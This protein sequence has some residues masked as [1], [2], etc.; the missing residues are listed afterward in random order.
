MKQKF[1]SLENILKEN[2][3]YNIIFGERSNGKTT[4]VLLYGLKRYVD[5]GYEK[6]MAIIRRW[7]EDFKG[8]K[9]SQLFAAIV[10]LGYVATYTNNL[11]NNVCYRAGK[12][13]LCNY[14]DDGKLVDISTEP[15]AYAFS[16][17][18]EE[19]YKSISFPNIKTV[20]FDE[21]ITR[22][23]Y[24]P[25]E[26]IKFQNLLSTIIRLNDDVKIFMCGNTVNQFCPYFVEMGLTR[27]ST[28]K[29]GTIDTYQYGEN[30]L[31]VAVEYSTFTAS[32]KRSNKY[33]AFDNPKLN[34]IK[35]GSWEIAI[36]PHLPVKYHP[37]EIVYKYY[38][39]FNDNLLQCEIIFSRILQTTFTF[40][41]RKTS[42]ISP[43]DPGLVFAQY[44]RPERR[45]R[46]NISRPTDKISSRIW[47]YFTD[48]KVFYQDNQIGE[49]VRNF[50]MQQKK[51]IT[52]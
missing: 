38:I 49:V 43:E 29:I 41:H 40:I 31:K 16:L 46:I 13:Y 26:F 33:F 11:F 17:T 9:A 10:N 37:S 7:D 23:Y 8:S 47:K 32:K 48:Q 27:I 50:I 44:I 15:F 52:L 28:Q 51:A 30:A 20:L 36:Y 2:A 5:S 14:S 18:S 4:S 6:Q 34:M 35:D 39:D 25:D 22:S 42:P 1:Y 3:D 24:L 19:H 45:Y 12:W 21:F